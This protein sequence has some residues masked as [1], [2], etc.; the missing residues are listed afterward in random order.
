[1]R[2]NR[3]EKPEPWPAALALGALVAPPDAVAAIAVLK[4]LRPPHRLRMILEGESLLNDA[5]AL[6]LYKLAI[7]AFVA[8]SFSVAT[9]VP[10]FVAVVLGSLLV[11][12]L[13]GRLIDR[14]SV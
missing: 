3:L 11:G 10:T 2:L 6:L 9:A 7:G 5:T 4:E 14:K 1:M 13:L 12:W 8:G